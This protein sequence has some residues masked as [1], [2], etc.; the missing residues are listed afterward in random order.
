MGYSVLK[1][2]LGKKAADSTVYSAGV[3][4]AKMQEIATAL[5]MKLNI[6][7]PNTTWILYMGDDSHNT[8][9]FKFSL[10]E[11]SLKMQTVIQGAIPS[12]SGYYFSNTVSL[13]TSTSS[14]AANAFLHYVVC[15]EGVVFGIGNINEES[16][17]TDLLH[18]VLPAKDLKTDEDRT[19]YMSFTSA[20]YI[21][22]SD[23]DEVSYYAQSWSQASNIHDVV[24]LAQ[25]VFPT[26][27]L[28]MPS[29]YYIL[30]GPDPATGAAGE[31]F[32]VNDQ[33]YFIP[34]NVGSI[35]RIAIELPNSE[36]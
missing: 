27:H 7:E 31:S 2:R 25:Y 6:I 28:A 5:G 29:A 24:S 21:I 3:D 16:N 18:I 4:D 9:G 30:A 36:Q 22:Y 12:S 19:A 13:S 26:R 1:I 8:T 11:Y 17:I 33:E 20:R 15:K 32:I 35:W 10:S 14:G 34:G 23:I